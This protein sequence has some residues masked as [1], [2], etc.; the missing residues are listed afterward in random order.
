MFYKAFRGLQSGTTTET[1]DNPTSVFGSSRKVSK[2]ELKVDTSIVEKPD[3]ESFEPGPAHD[4]KKEQEI[5]I[6]K[7]KEQPDPQGALKIPLR[8]KKDARRPTVISVSCRVGNTS[9]ADGGQQAEDLDDKHNNKILPNGIPANCRQGQQ[10]R[11][12]DDDAHTA[13]VRLCCKAIYFHAAGYLEAP[14]D[15]DAPGAR[16][17]PV[18]S[19]PPPC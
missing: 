14:G 16:F 2:L 3:Q 6:A 17:E 8:D 11:A 13:C 9:A 1:G 18:L 7:S 15:G 19:R 10:R 4:N 5:K 12:F